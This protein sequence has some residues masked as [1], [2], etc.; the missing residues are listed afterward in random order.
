MQLRH[1]AIPHFRNLRDVVIDFATQLSPMPGAA[2][3]AAPKSI[4]S[5]A[6]TRV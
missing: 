4:R 3:D 1:L 2:A 5:H 6:L